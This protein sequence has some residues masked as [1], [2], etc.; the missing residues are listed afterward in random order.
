MLTHR[1]RQ[2]SNAS[3]LSGG[4]TAAS[5]A[6]GGSR[7]SATT[8]ATAAPPSPKPAAPPSAWSCPVPPVACLL[9]RRTGASSWP[10]WPP[11][12]TGSRRRMS[13]ALTVRLWWGRWSPRSSE[14]GEHAQRGH[15]RV[16][17]KKKHEGLYLGTWKKKCWKC[18]L[19][20]LKNIIY[21]ML[22]R[23]P[24]TKKTKEKCFLYLCCVCYGAL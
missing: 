12:A 18:S 1:P 17:G 22:S 10:R 3:G 16:G 6:G 2:L 21:V 14:W 23:N 4:P 7:W 9:Y 15:T 13:R 20:T 11:T 24:K 5:S 19:F 8:S